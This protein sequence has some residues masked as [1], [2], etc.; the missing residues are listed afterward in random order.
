MGEYTLMTSQKNS[1]LECIKHTTL[2]PFNFRWSK[3]TSQHTIA[4]GKYA[5]VSKL[6]YINTDYYFIFDLIKGQHYCLFSPGQE[7]LHDSQYPGSWF[8]VLEYIKKWLEYIEREIRQP[9]LWDELAKHK[10]SY[11]GNI[12]KETTNEPFSV[13]QAQQITGGIEKIRIYLVNEFK[14]DYN[15]KEL[16]NEKLDYLVDATKRQGRKDWFHTCIGVFVS[17]ATALAMSPEQT[18]NI[19]MILKTAVS[20][21]I[22]LIQG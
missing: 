20:G 16:I 19:W 17:M 12:A 2:D 18:N 10:I 4:D 3:V 15:S 5:R 1:V 13:S 6:S 7:K 11:D 21:I 9:D 8:F 22:K 14:D